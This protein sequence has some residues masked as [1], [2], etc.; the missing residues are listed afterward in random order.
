VIAVALALGAAVAWGGADF[1]GG[2][3]SRAAGT[4]VV[5]ALSQA[6]GLA[7]VAAVVTARAEGPPEPRFLAYSALAGVAGAVGIGALYHGLAVGAMSIVAPITATGAAIPVVVGVATGERPTAL[8]GAGLALALG[9]VVLAAR[10]REGEGLGVRLATGVGLALLA[11]LGIGSFLVA[12]DA[13]SEGGVAWALLVQRAVCLG[14]VLTAAA[15]VRPALGAARLDLMPML[16]IGVLDMSANALFA[17][18]STRGL[19]SL[20]SVLASLYPVTTVVLARLL[21]GERI[22][23]AQEVGVVGALAGVVLISAG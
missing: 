18:A 10:Q 3:K 15:V 22:G 13:A 17:L 7:L 23:R 1:L 16:A 21:L 11:A 5:V 14:L 8:Q 9:G 6:A 19:L 2:L 20:V 4:L 12:L